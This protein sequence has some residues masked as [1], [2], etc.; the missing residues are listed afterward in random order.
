MYRKEEA[1]DL[2]NFHTLDDGSTVSAPAQRWKSAV[3]MRIRTTIRYPRSEPLMLDNSVTQLLQKSD[4]EKPKAAQKVRENLA[5]R[6]AME[7]IISGFPG[8]G[9]RRITEASRR[10]GWSVNQKRVLT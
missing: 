5:L 2:D 1:D 4:I 9:Y 6:D 3:D 8:Y 7:G 10:E